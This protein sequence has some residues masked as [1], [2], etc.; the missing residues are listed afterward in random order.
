M[1]SIATQPQGTFDNEKIDAAAALEVLAST[2]GAAMTFA[3]A[4]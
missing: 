4:L 2:T 3:G 1:I